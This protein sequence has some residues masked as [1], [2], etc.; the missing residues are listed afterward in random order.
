MNRKIVLT[1]LAFLA[2]AVPTIQAAGPA[3]IRPTVAYVTPDDVDGYDD[4]A[5]IGFAAGAA[6]GAGRQHE[7][8]GE[9]GAMGWEFDERVGPVRVEATETYVPFLASYR[10][11]THPVE[12]K[13]RF[14]FGPSIGFT[15]ARYDIESRSSFYSV[16]DEAVEYLFSFA[17]NLGFDINLTEKLSLNVGYRYLYISSGETELFDA[18]ID[19][20]ELKSHMVVAGLNI[21]F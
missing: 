21:R 10:Y 11:Y 4:A 20:D 9:I 3:F 6:V 14:Y 12:S 17:A 2:L 15:V 18:Q 19:F 7:I 5:Y 1:G 16:D 13:V 8:S